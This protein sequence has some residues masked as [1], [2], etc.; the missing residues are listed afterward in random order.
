MVLLVWVKTTRIS[1]DCFIVTPFNILRT[2]THRKCMRQNVY[3]SIEHNNYKIF[4]IFLIHC[5]TS[6]ITSHHMQHISH[7]TSP[8]VPHPMIRYISSMRRKKGLQNYKHMLFGESQLARE[9]SGFKFFPCRSTDADIHSVHNKEGGSC[10][11]FN[12]TSLKTI[13]TRRAHDTGPLFIKMGVGGV[14]PQDIAKSRSRKI[15]CY[16]DRIA[17][18]FDRRFCRDACQILDRLEKSKPETRGFETSQ[19]LAVRRPS[20]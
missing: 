10:L 14:L 11:F 5:I 17:L 20:A 2:C 4:I 1:Q 13:C 19:D 15:R 9:S 16:N 18:K 12:V 8:H 3:I 7:P 6:P